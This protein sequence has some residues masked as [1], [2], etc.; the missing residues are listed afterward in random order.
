MKKIFILLVSIVSLVSCTKSKIADIKSNSKKQDDLSINEIKSNLKESIVKINCYDLKKNQ[1]ISQGTGFFIDYS[2]TFITNHHVVEEAFF[3]EIETFSGLKRWVDNVNFYN[4]TTSD[5]AICY[6]NRL[7][8]KPVAF[9]EKISNNDK[10]FALGYPNNSPVL[11]TSEGHIVKTETVANKG[12]KY[13]ENTASI[14]HGSSGGILS[15]SHGNVIG[16][17]SCSLSS[18]NFGAIPYSAFKNYLNIKTVNRDPIHAFHNVQDVVLVPSNVNMYFNI[19][20]SADITVKSNTDIFTTFTY[21]IKVRNPNNLVISS[22]SNYVCFA[23][24]FSVMYTYWLFGGSSSTLYTK[25]ESYSKNVFLY[26]NNVVSG[27]TGTEIVGLVTDGQGRVT[28]KS[29]PSVAV[30]DVSGSIAI[31]S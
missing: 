18:K 9:S 10:V 3:V 30:P 6:V 20:Y 29:N 12:V 2:G 31:V 13:I 14:D 22:G 4:K 21:S 27:L 19:S 11:I 25:T 17:T 26:E 28:K 23:L 24:K 7:S 5:F 8:S 16:I 1:I 15:D